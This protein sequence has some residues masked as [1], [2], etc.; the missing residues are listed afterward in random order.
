MPRQPRFDLPGLPQHLVQRGNDRR[1]CF[2]API[3]RTRCLDE[4]RDAASRHGCA[5]HAYVLMTHHVHLLLTPAANGCVSAMMLRWGVATSATSTIATAAPARFG[6]AASGPARC[7]P[8]ITCCAAT[9]KNNRDIELN[10][11]RA[12][13][14]SQPSGYPWSSYAANAQGAI[15]PLV[16]PQPQYLA[17][18][19]EDMARQRLYREWVQSAIAPNEVAPDEVD[20]IRR[21]LQCQHAFGTERFRQMIEEQLQRRAGTAKIGRPRKP[22]HQAYAEVALRPMLL[23]KVSMATGV[24]LSPSYRLLAQWAAGSRLSSCNPGRPSKSCV[25]NVTKRYP[26]SIACAAIHKSL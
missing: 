6:K 25:L 3:D 20:E 1:P 22:A 7:S 2:F 19:A 16:S 24:L 17:L 10:P 9:S 21:R 12:R 26:C 5:V 11:V 8:T 23:P 15:D 4:L 13:R 18:D 14:V